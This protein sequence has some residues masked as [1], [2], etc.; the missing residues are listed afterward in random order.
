MHVELTAAQRSFLDSFRAYLDGLDASGFD[1]AAIAGEADSDLQEVGPRGQAFLRRMGADGWLGIGWP[2]EHGGRGATAIEQWLFREELEYRGLPHG[3]MALTSIGPTLMRVGTADQQK[4]YLRSILRGEIEF[5]LGYTEPNAGS[6]LAGLQTRAVRDGDRYVVDGQKVYTTAAHYASHIWLAARTGEAGSRH[7][8][9]SVLVLP[10]DAPGVTV[11]PL[12]TQSDGRTNEVF[13][14]GVEVPISERVGA[15][16]EGWNVIAMALDFERLL[17]YARNR[18]Y[19]DQLLA[20]VSERVNE[21]AGDRRTQHR[22]AR[23]VAETEAARLL[24]MRTASMIDAGAVPN[25]EASMLKVRLSEL[26]QH[27]ALDAL[28]IVGPAAQ[29]R[30][31]TTGAPAGGI[32]ERLW[33]ASTVLKFAGGTN[34][35][36]RNI[37]AQR[38]LGLPR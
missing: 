15:E 11:R 5:A 2:V 26:R 33:R 32:F 38:G 8:G 4:R 28:A 14:E 22:I 18:Y 34:E 1:L 3:G 31:G 29:L 24:A 23:L 37:I 16:N 30:I 17:P 19:L 36:Q 20:W 27:I 10:I 25:V 6:D 13:L 12:F 7:K 9:I 35:V 21:G